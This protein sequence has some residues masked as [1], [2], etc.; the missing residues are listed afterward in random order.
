MIIMPNVSVVAVLVV[1]LVLA[2]GVV[3][4][5]GDERKR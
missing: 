3:L 1:W 5:F 2:F 4:L